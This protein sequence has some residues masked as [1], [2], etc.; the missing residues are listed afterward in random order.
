VL[1]LTQVIAVVRAL[2]TGRLRFSGMRSGSSSFYWAEQ[3]L[4]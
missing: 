2:F 1:E 3:P 4:S